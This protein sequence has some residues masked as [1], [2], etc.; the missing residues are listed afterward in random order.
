MLEPGTA[1]A[2]AFNGQYPRLTQNR[3]QVQFSVQ[4]GLWQMICG[5]FQGPGDFRS[6]AVIPLTQPG[7][8]P[9]DVQVAVNVSAAGYAVR[10]NEQTLIKDV[11]LFFKGGLVGLATSG[12][13][14]RFDD[15]QV[16]K[17][18]EGTNQAAA[19]TP[20]ALAAPPPEATPAPARRRLPRQPI[21]SMKLRSTA[22]LS[23]EHWQRVAGYPL[24]GTG[25]LI[26]GVWSNGRWKAMTWG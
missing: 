21:W 15:L 18:G 17:P 16:F 24:P 9:L 26:T 2:L 20:T 22:A 3:H 7:D 13:S 8:Q 1:A 19:A 23:R 4:D 14:A 10:V 25:R 12:G 6:Q 5:Y 11:P